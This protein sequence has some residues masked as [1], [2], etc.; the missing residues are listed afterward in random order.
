VVGSEENFSWFTSIAAGDDHNERSPFGLILIPATN[1][2]DMAKLDSQSFE[3]SY[4]FDW[5]HIEWRR[6]GAFECRRRIE[7]R[8][9]FKECQYK[10]ITIV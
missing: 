8:G 1:P 4:A 10:E 3:D 9:M 2:S 5:E 7:S 6:V